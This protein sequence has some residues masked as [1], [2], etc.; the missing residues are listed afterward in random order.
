MKLVPQL[1]AMC[2]A[3]ACMAAQAQVSGTGLYVGGSLGQSKWKGDT[4]LGV[5][6]TQTGGKIYGGYEFTPHF[7]L[8][9]GYADL[10]DFS[11]PGGAIKATGY[12]LDA[13]GKFEFAPRW[14]ALAR[15]GA[16]Q[17]KIQ[18]AGTSERGTAPK[19]GLGLQYDLT[20]NAAIRTEYE[21]YRFDALNAKPDTDLWSVGLNYRF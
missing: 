10:G 3:G 7:G 15:L 19:Y 12:Y 18:G 20:P 21:R 6:T 17:G 16:F 4:S 11:Y 2:V 13:V 5:D 1:V 9:L 14:S 8:E